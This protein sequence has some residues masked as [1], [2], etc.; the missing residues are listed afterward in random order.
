[1]GL[2]AVLYTTIIILLHQVVATT[3]QVLSYISG[4]T[5]MRMYVVIFVVHA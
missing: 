3:T 5:R 1:M 2:T 4:M